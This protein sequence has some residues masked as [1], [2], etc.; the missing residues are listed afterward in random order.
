MYNVWQD[1][2][3]ALR[4]LIRSSRFSLAVLA[5]L[6]ITVGANIIIY[7]VVDAVLLRPLSLPR[8]ERLVDLN[9]AR[10][11]Q[12]ADGALE[13]ESWVAENRTLEAV[14]VYNSGTV[15]LGGNREQEPIRAAQV[16]SGFFAVTRRT[17]SGESF[18]PA[19]ARI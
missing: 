8:S 6:A 9:G 16:S 14:A 18:H 19:R 2:R 7:S 3:F 5:T 10:W 15:S 11:K 13:V 1:V 17:V 12:E 4:R